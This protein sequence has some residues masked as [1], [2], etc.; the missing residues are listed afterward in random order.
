MPPPLNPNVKRDRRR[1]KKLPKATLH[2]NKEVPL[3]D[4]VIMGIMGGLLVSILGLVL[5]EIFLFILECEREHRFD[6]LKELLSS[7]FLFFSQSEN[8][9]L[10]KQFVA[11]GIYF[12]G[13]SIL[14]LPY[15][16]FFS[17]GWNQFP[18]IGMT[19]LTTTPKSTSTHKNSKGNANGA[20]T[21]HPTRLMTISVPALGIAAFA[22]GLCALGAPCITDPQVPLSYLFIW[23][24]FAIPYIYHAI[25]DLVNVPRGDIIEQ[26]K[27]PVDVE[28]DINRYANK[29]LP[30]ILP[31][32]LVQQFESLSES[33]NQ[34]KMITKNIVEKGKESEINPF[35]NLAERAKQVIENLNDTTEKEPEIK[36]EAYHCVLRQ[37]RPSFPSEPPGRPSRHSRRE[38][39]HVL[40]TQNSLLKEKIKRLEKANKKLKEAAVKKEKDHANMSKFVETFFQDSSFDKSVAE[41][42][43]ETSD[44][45]ATPPSTDNSVEEMEK[46]VEVIEEEKLDA[47]DEERLRDLEKE[48]R[49]AGGHESDDG[50]LV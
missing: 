45:I 5:M 7:L 18:R 46:V 24:S 4:E 17:V 6:P 42:G 27:K 11:F 21:S 49:E 29:T 50:V 14:E 26:Q 47:D 40:E 22:F 15:E 37:W 23:A 2:T 43:E 38:R 36:M 35:T 16:L 13:S 20:K 48:M 33:L 30:E 1:P 28:G 19:N 9:V 10:F 34:L 3:L 32:S 25:I 12:L 8:L 31:S 44:A 39:I 41:E